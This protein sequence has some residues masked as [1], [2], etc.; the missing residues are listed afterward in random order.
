MSH[1]WFS[2]RR[3]ARWLPWTAGALSLS[4][5]PAVPA[6]PADP[7]ASQPATRVAQAQASSIRRH[8]ASRSRMCPVRW[9]SG[10]I[11]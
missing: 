2:C 7:A 9:A 10:W 5:G 1:K 6:P 11:V 3:V 8:T 4:V